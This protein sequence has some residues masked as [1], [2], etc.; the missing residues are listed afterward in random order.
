MGRGS[1]RNTILTGVVGLQTETRRPKVEGS[2]G[3]V[4]R[5]VSAKAV[6]PHHVNMEISEAWAVGKPTSISFR[7]SALGGKVSYTACPH[8]A[9]TDKQSL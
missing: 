5:L 1:G 4:G 8:T 3:R 9:P 6:K 7:S 2:V